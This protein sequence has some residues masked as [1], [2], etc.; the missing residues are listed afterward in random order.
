MSNIVIDTWKVPVAKIGDTRCLGGRNRVPF[1][2]SDHDEPRTPSD[3]PTPATTGRCPNFRWVDPIL[4]TQPPK[5]TR[6][7]ISIYP[8]PKTARAVDH[9]GPRHTKD[10]RKRPVEGKR[11]AV[12]GLTPSV[13]H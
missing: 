12:K 7:P 3:W 2:F 9:N 10:V 8:C 11:T 13:P 6:Y 1:Y 4:A 5:G